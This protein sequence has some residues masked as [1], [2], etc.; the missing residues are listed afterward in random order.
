MCW[1]QQ[2]P[3]QAEVEERER[4]GFLEALWKLSATETTWVAA[5]T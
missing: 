2:V 3:G 5:G 1:N 4:D